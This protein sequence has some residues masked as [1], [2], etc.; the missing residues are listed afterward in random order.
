LVESY[1]DADAVLAHMNGPAV[2]EFVPKMLEVSSLT[3]FHI[4]GDPGAKAEQIVSGMGAKIFARWA[5]LGR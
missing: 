4:Y 2:K 1:K 5:G 3:D